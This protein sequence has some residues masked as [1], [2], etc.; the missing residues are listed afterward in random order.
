MMQTVSDVHVLVLY[1][2]K[3]LTSSKQ[4]DRSALRSFLNVM[5]SLFHFCDSSTKRLTPTNVNN[6]YSATLTVSATR[7]CRSTIESILQQHRLDWL[8]A[9]MQTTVL[10]RHASDGS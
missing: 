8:T 6:M 10:P 5:S 1:E 9:A 2:A 7:F 4:V 3:L